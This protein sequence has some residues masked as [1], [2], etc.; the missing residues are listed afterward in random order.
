MRLGNLPLLLETILLSNTKSLDRQPGSQSFESFRNRASAQQSL[1][2]ELETNCTCTNVQNTFALKSNL[3]LN[4]I[5]HGPSRSTTYKDALCCRASPHSCCATKIFALCL[6]DCFDGCL[7]DNACPFC[8]CALQQRFTRWQ[9]TGG[10]WTFQGC[11]S[12]PGGEHS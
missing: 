7:A 3:C 8:A 9:L 4:T 10:L 6:N 12:N 1:H 5:F 11:L 2:N